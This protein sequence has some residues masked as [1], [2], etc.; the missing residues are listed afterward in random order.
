MT[1][2]LFQTM[3]ANRLRQLANTVEEYRVAKGLSKE[4]LVKLVPQVGSSKTFGK[5]LADDL[6]ELDLDAQ[7]ANYQAA[8]AWIESIGDDR[9][10]E[11]VIHDDL[12]AA[13]AVKRAFLQTIKE[14]GNARVILIQG[15]SGSG[16]TSSRRALVAK[17]GAR[18]ICIEATV[19]WNDSP[20]A[21]LGALLKALGKKEMPMT[22]G[23]RLDKAVELM[24]DTRRALA[25]EEAQHCGPRILNVI[26]T[27]VN[28]TP[29]EFLLFALDT[30]WDRLETRAYAEAHQLIGNRLAERINL[31]KEIK[32]RDVKLFVARRVTLA[33]EANADDIAKHLI[34]HA[35]GNGRF[36]FI[37]DVCLRVVEANAGK[38]V[39]KAAF[40]EAMQ[41]EISSR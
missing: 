11:E 12:T 3:E 38:A 27:L 5:I 17:Y 36:A 15:P 8:V 37:R 40:I 30:L 14:T 33:P 4:A 41:L 25:I 20:N 22:P 35:L 29:G 39:E 13:I 31:G 28:Q 21:F 10:E 32:P 19:A 7:L 24:R 23:E 18:I 16:K 6:S 1:P 9:A 34:H 2:E 26:K